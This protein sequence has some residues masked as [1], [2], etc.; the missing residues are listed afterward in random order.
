M[1]QVG[2]NRGANH[3]Y[4]LMSVEDIAALP[5]S[6]LTRDS[7]HLWLWVTNATLFAGRRVMDA[8]GFTY[9]AV[10]TW[11]K[12]YYGMGQYLRTQTEHLLLGTKGR[13]PVRFKGQGSWFYAPVQE[14]S[15]KP[16]EQYAIIERC[17]PGPYLELFARR[18]RPGWQVWGNQVAGDVTL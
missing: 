11:V 10:L 3:H 5:V 14:H 15:H 12:P 18:L 2:G 17:S 8:W 7:A 6:Q 13:A 16:E 9:R 1:L 4:Q